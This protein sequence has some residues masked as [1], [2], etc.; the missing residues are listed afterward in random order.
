MSGTFCH[1]L[2]VTGERMRTA[3]WLIASVKPAQEQCRIT[4]RPKITSAVYR[5]RKN[6]QNENNVSVAGLF[7]LRQTWS[8]N[9]KTDFFLTALISIHGVL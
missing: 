2:S 4:D 8:H 3:Y 1:Q 9:P 6:K 7:S 5:G